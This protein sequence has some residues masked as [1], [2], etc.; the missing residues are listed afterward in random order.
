MSGRNDRVVAGM[1]FFLSLLFTI[2]YFVTLGI[3]LF[4]RANLPAEQIRL[5][6]TLFGVLSAVL[7]QQSGYWFSRQ[8]GAESMRDAEVVQAMM[9]SQQM[10]TVNMTQPEARPTVINNY[11]AKIVG[12]DRLRPRRPL[13]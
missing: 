11:N 5:V 9:R 13:N 2:G 10:P 7:V 8:R 4:G 6:D 1:Q 3:V 12:H